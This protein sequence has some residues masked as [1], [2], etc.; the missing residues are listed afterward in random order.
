MANRETDPAGGKRRGK[1]VQIR[2]RSSRL[3]F[4]S[5]GQTGSKHCPSYH[6]LSTS[7]FISKIIFSGWAQGLCDP[8]LIWERAAETYQ[9]PLA[10][11]LQLFSSQLGMVNSCAIQIATRKRGQHQSDLLVSLIP[12]GSARNSSFCRHMSVPGLKRENPR[13]ENSGFSP[14]SLNGQTID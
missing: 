5:W 14:P 8:S 4:G 10:H 6:Q 9:L 1:S 13:T 2:V 3:K 11:S 7:A 12:R